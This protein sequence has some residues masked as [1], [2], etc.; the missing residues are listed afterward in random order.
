[1]KK[2]IKPKLLNNVLK[3]IKQNS[4]KPITNIGLL[5]KYIAQSLEGDNLITFYNW[6]C[7]PR[8]ISKTKEGK[9]FINYDIDIKSISNGKKIDH[10][11]E[12]P[13]VIEQ[14]EREKKILKFLNTL[15][16]KYR[17]AKLIADTNIYYLTPDTVKILGRKKIMMK[18]K[19]F[20]NLIIEKSKQYPV[21]VEV[22]LFTELTKKYKK[23]YKESFYKT[24]NLLKKNPE[25]IIPKKFLKQQ[26]SRTRNHV[27][28]ESPDK[29]ED[30]SL[31][32]IASYASEGIIFDLLSKT[33]DFSNCV[34]LNIEEVDQRVIV[35][36][37]C[38][39]H[40]KNLEELPMVF[41][42]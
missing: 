29:I 14:P 11:T 10:F 39:R 26:F 8:S 15:G 5:R 3:K 17:F 33:K 41:L 7:P 2:I 9:V 37:N 36:T 4:Q 19:E 1:M 6:E 22:Y 12:L 24:F 35:I 40:K 42:K 21:K 32:T 16:I 25:E 31:R 34:W 18:L 27:G 13:R 30:F 20:K 28:L 23:V 38:L